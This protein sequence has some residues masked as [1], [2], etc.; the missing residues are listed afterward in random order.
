M[1]FDHLADVRLEKVEKC[2]LRKTRLYGPLGLLDGGQGSAT[3]TWLESVPIWL[4]HS[5]TSL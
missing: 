3:H 2:T 4:F 5:I 1:P